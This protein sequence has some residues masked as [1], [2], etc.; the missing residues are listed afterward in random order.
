ML[1]GKPNS[2]DFRILV[3]CD[4]AEPSPAPHTEQVREKLGCFLFGFGVFHVVKKCIM[5][6]LEGAVVASAFA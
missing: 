5:E 1:G 6:V 2:L 4:P 3:G